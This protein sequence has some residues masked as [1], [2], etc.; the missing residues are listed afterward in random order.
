MSHTLKHTTSWIWQHRS[1]PCRNYHL[2][3]NH[4]VVPSTGTSGC[5]CP[6]RQLLLYLQCHHRVTYAQRMESS[7][8][9]I[10]HISEVPHGVWDRRSMYGLDGHSRMLHCHVRNERSFVGIKHW[11]VTSCSRTNERPRGDLLRRQH[12]RPYPSCHQVGWS[13]S[14]QRARYLLEE[15]SRCLRLEPREHARD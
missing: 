10:P 15:Q 12:P 14:L 1:L 13:C 3:S 6:S 9:Y 2:I 7:L 5:Q 4:W 11:G 8:I